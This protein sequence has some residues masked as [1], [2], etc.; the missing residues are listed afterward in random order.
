MLALAAMGWVSLTSV[1]TASQ[2]P[3]GPQELQAGAVQDSRIPGPGSRIPDSGQLATMQ[4]V[5]RQ[6]S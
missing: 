1:F 2:A 4:Q 6:L 5:L 3:S